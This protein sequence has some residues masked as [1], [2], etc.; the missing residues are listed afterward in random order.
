M[1]FTFTQDD[2]LSTQDFIKAAEDR[3]YRLSLDD[4]Q[5]FHSNR[6]FLPL[7]RVSDTPVDERRINVVAN[8]NMNDRWKALKAAQDGR[9]CDS[10]HEGYSSAWPYRCPPNGQGR[11]WWNGFLYSSW[12]L[13]DLDIVVNE[14]RGLLAGPD[15]AVRMRPAEQ[16]RKRVLALA[17]LAP[18]YLPGILGKLSIPPGID[19]GELRRFRFKSDVQNLLS[20]VGFDPAQLRTEAERLLLDAKRD[21]LREWLPLVRHANHSAWSKLQGE[22]LDCLWLRIGAE[23]LLRAHEELA[24]S[25]E[26]ESLPDITEAKWLTPLHD[27]L[28]R[29]SSNAEPLDRALGKFGLSPYP[30]ALILVEGE[31]EPFHSLLLLEQF[32]LNQPGQVRVQRCKGSGVNPQLLARYAISPRIGGKLGD[33]WQLTATPTALVI[34]MGPENMWDTP[35]KREIQRKKIQESIREEVELQGGQIGDTELDFLVNIYVWHDDLRYELANFTDDELLPAITSLATGPHAK[36][37]ES[38]AWQEETRR[39]LHALRSKDYAKIDPVIGTLRI[40]KTTLAETLW[41][42]LLAKC[43][44]ELESD[45]IETPMLKVILE[46]QK[47]RVVAVGWELCP[48]CGKRRGFVVIGFISDVV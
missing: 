18:R 39:K 9:L 38:D 46:T 33:S 8:G 37:V 16:R 41:P 11:R 20:A 32:G 36:N 10:A 2:L 43:E 4:L 6:L 44:R 40:G 30:R 22:A 31:I 27:R 26:I 35:K 42:T 7:Y 5:A 23:I 1:P 12:Q 19:E 17:A 21:P 13:L 14:Q 45:V 48:S 25:G 34:A 29:T 24:A 28:G 47:N 15:K 3:G